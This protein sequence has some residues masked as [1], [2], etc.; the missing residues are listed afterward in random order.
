MKSLV[1]I[2]LI[3][4]LYGCSETKRSHQYQ[5]VIVET[6]YTE[7]ISIRALEIMDG[8]IAFAGNNGLFGAIDVR[9]HQIRTSRETYDTIAPEFRAVGHTATDFFMLS[10]GRPALLYKTGDTGTM[11]LVYKEDEEG[12]F[13]DA[14]KF[15]N[16]EEGIALGDAMG[17]CLSII[18]TRDGGRS[19][20]KLPCKQLP[21]AMAGEGAFAASNTNIDIVGDNTWIGTT[22]SRIF[23]SP[24]KGVTW[25]VIQAPII[26]KKETEGIYSIDFETSDLGVAVGGDYTNPEN[27]EATKAITRDGG[28]SWEL[29]ANGQLPGY[30]SC[31]QFVPGS[32]GNDLVLAGFTGISY[33]GDMGQTWKEFSTESFYTLRFVNDSVAYAAGKNRIAKLTFK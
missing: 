6:I 2:V 18:I 1:A 13:Y 12:V 5:E 22:Q 17:G 7:Q 4:V 27:T 21:P 11:E 20:D 25:E 26:H 28:K 23:Y 16:N 30:K 19:W 10:A 33:S 24:D 8:S 9:S 15:W 31:V 14:M 29:L 32:G 3:F